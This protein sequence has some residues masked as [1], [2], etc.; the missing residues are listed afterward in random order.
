MWP[1]RVL[2]NLRAN[3]DPIEAVVSNGAKESPSSADSSSK[4]HKLDSMWTPELGA[5]EGS[6]TPAH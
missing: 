5:T 6:S 1:R 4:D 2:H 3:G